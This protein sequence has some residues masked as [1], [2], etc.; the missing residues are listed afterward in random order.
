M[1]W[2]SRYGV[3]ASWKEKVASSK[4]KQKRNIAELVGK[5]LPRLIDLSQLIGQLIGDTDVCENHTARVGRNSFSMGQQGQHYVET[6][7]V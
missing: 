5:A 4:T 2:Y 3:L 7:V 6:L 1:F